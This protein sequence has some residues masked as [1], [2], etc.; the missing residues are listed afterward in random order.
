MDKKETVSYLD[1][2]RFQSALIGAVSKDKINHLL[3][4]EN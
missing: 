3:A 4:F 1:A 2:V